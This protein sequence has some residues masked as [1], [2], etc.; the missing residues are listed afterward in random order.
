MWHWYIDIAVSEEPPATTFRAGLFYPEM[1]AQ[2]FL[3]IFV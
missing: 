3:E 2:I 1:K